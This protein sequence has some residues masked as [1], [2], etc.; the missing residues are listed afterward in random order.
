VLLVSTFGWNT[1]GRLAVAFADAGFVVEAIGPSNSVVHVIGA[2]R[3]SYLLHV[4]R[5]V[6]TIRRAIEQGDP[7]LVVATDDPSRQALHRVY[8]AA[9][10]E[11]E[12]GLVARACLERSLGPPETYDQIYSRA[13][14]IELATSRGLCA[15]P[16]TQ[17]AS[18]AEA[19][20]WQRGHGGP[21]VV[22]TDG[23]WGGR[24]VMIAEDAA[25][26][27]VAWRRLSAPPSAVRVAKRLLL[28]RSPWPLRDRLGRR[29]PSVSIQAYVPGRPANVA[30]ACLDGEVLAAVSAEVVVSARP[31]GP[32]TVLKVVDHPEMAETAA[33]IVAAFRLTGLC[34]FDFVLEPDTGRPHLVEL[35]PRATPTAHLLTADGTDP[36]R[37]LGAALMRQAPPHRGTPYAQGLVALFPQELERDPD[38]EYVAQ[39]YHDVPTHAQ[40]FVEK[41]GARLAARLRWDMPSPS[42]G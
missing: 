13:A 2:V 35:N 34:G 12:R 11:T 4:V 25:D 37:F 28:D 14:L 7:D 39:A 15:P 8:A 42:V 17:V 33:S 36:L 29:R 10:P 27:E 6:A 1:A 9:D 16:T 41:A 38:S 22:K 30:V 19:V 31:T 23:S 20:A 5:P 26:V 21:V 3:R 32:A 40:D 24:G 18:A